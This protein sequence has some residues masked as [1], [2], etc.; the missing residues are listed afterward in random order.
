MKDW[1]R[2]SKQARSY[3]AYSSVL[4]FHTTALPYPTRTLLFLRNFRYFAL[5][6]FWHKN[7][8]NSTINLQFSVRGEALHYFLDLDSFDDAT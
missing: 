3:V 6:F 8:R 4:I 5:S 1:K 2:G 7:V